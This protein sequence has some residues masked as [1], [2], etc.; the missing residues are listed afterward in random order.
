MY[1]LHLG[2]IRDAGLG[3][4]PPEYQTSRLVRTSP[5]FVCWGNQPSNPFG[6]G[7]FVRSVEIGLHWLTSGED[8]AG[9]PGSS[10]RRIILG[11]LDGVWRDYM[12]Y[13]LT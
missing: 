9:M 11:I 12:G 1:R 6:L 4:G 13:V 2:L 10:F 5:P 8:G 7:S 3:S